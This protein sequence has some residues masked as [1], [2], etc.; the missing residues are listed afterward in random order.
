MFE[1]IVVITNMAY[2]MTAS[3]DLFDRTLVLGC[4][5]YIT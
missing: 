1:Y 4:P 5:T 2:H 3:Y